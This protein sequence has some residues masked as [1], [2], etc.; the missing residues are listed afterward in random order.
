MFKHDQISPNLKKKKKDERKEKRHPS[1]AVLPTQIPLYMV[2]DVS[3]SSPPSY[4][5]AHWSLASALTFLPKLPSWSARVNVSVSLLPS[6]LQQ[7]CLNHLKLSPLLD[8]VSWLRDT[9]LYWFFSLDLLSFSGF[10]EDCLSSF[11]LVNVGI[12]W[13][14][15]MFPLTLFFSHSTYPPK[16]I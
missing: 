9:K 16:E 1:A 2:C 3:I 6:L 4:G 12:P 15:E 5:S 13:S 10:F 14:F 11:P 8:H 7:T